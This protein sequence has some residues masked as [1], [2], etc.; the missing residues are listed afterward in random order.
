MNPEEGYI[1]FICHHENSGRV[2]PDAVYEKVN[3]IRTQLHSQGLIGIYPDG[4]GFGNISF[5]SAGEKEFFITGT[6]T[7]AYPVADPKHFALVNR[8]DI[9]NNT[10]WCKGP[11]KASSE[12][13]SHAAVYELLEEVSCVI[14]VHHLGL[15]KKLATAKHDNVASTPA[16]I[17]YGTPRMA[18]ALRTIIRNQPSCNVIRM[19]GHIEGI[20]AFGNTP[21]KTEATLLQLF[22]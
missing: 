10:I 9:D 15:W 1:K 17:P 8:W 13:M 16:H 6:A 14:H 22:D 4:I 21:M 2:I 11:V 18:M 12:T 19:A 3:P 5:R 7:G 20:V